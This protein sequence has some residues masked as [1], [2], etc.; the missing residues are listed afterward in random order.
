MITSLKKNMRLSAL[1]VMLA[2]ATVACNDDYLLSPEPAGDGGDGYIVFRCTDMLETFVGQ[3][4]PASRAGGS[5][6]PEEK[7]INTL[8]I[9]FFDDETGNLLTQAYDNFKPYQKVTNTSLIKIPTGEGVPSNYTDQMKKVRI[10]AIANIDATDEATSADEPANQF[11]TDYSEGG[12]IQRAGR[13][14]GGEPHKITKYSDLEEWI[15]YPRI[16]MSADGTEG[17][18]SKLPESGMPMIG[19]LGN[20]KLG[21]EPLDLS[22]KPTT[23]TVVNMRALMAKVNVSVELEPDQSTEQYPL[24]KITG[25]GVRNMPIA[26]PFRQP[27]TKVIDGIGG[28][29]T[30][31]S[32]DERHANYFKKYEVTDVPMFH[33]GDN[34]TGNSHFVCDDEAHE[35]MNT[36]NVTINKDSEPV[37]FSYYTFENIN[38]PDYNAKRA[39]NV[40]AFNEA[41]EPQYPT[42]V[43]EADKQRW[44]STFAYS[45][46][47]SALILKGEYTTHQGLTYKAQF[48]VYMGCTVGVPDPNID[49]QVK[50]NHRYDNNII[51]HGLDYIRNSDDDVY[52][53]DGRVNVVDDNPFYLAIVNE[54]KVDAHA[55]ALPMDV[56][57]MM[58]EDGSGNLIENP[59]WD[60]EITFTIRDHDNKK[61]N[62]IRMEKIPRSVMEEGRE[63]EVDGVMQK[64][65]F[66]PGTG[67]RNY[68]TTDLVTSTLWDNGEADGKEHGYEITVDGD[69]DLSRT[70]IYFYIDEN[71]PPTNNPNTTNPN[72][73][74]YYG[75]RT[76]VIDIVYT[77]KEDGV[78]VDRRVRTLEIEQRALLKVQTNGSISWMEFYEEY[79]DHNDP[80]DPHTEYGEFYKDGLPWGLE[81]VNV[82]SNFTN[83]EVDNPNTSLTTNP[84][85]Q[86]YYKIGGFRMT[87]WA[88]N[89]RGD[90]DPISNVTLFN[91]EKPASAFHY[92]FGKN[93]RNSDGSA[94]YEYEQTRRQGFF[95]SYITGNTAKGWYMP[96]I[97]EL[98]N[99]LLIYYNNFSDFRGNFYW[100]AACANKSAQTGNNDQHAR[101][102]K[103]I[104]ENSS[105]D[106]AKS[107]PQDGNNA[108][109]GP[110]YQTRDTKNRIRA[111]YRVD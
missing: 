89:E 67:A 87:V 34:Q 107:H 78:E 71:V 61:G 31:N 24:L 49:F 5:K 111:F 68:F 110:G 80:L 72:A 38:L 36:A 51:I 20:T 103:I 62:W 76:A 100:S 22:K 55:T 84:A 86:V 70:R 17:D 40:D 3:H 7:A 65:P 74:D 73:A 64:I 16:R 29:P 95:G 27:T 94:V 48:T 102:T 28:K 45:D 91:T 15:Y 26:V 105:Y 35:F 21:Q 63:V 75:D 53:F 93:K 42:G 57:F 106:Y 81:N 79:L 44:K 108:S 23:A 90:T 82:N 10:V 54:R 11:F 59:S 4:N 109:S 33:K 2:A 98:E 9:F 32:D 56:W 13:D 50:R 83:D 25:Y 19:E 39:N 104:Y 1:G 41:L 66:Y 30:G 58:R 43:K 92:C 8:H 14:K 60:S 37:T 52:N 46:R 97:T 101:A 96:G 6:N 88:V 69:V 77:R 12:R 18:I 47:A 99:A 85:Y